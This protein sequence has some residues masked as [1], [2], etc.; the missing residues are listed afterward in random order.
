M[1]LAIEDLKQRAAQAQSAIG[2][3]AILRPPVDPATGL[4]MRQSTK[5]AGEYREAVQDTLD[6]FGGV[7][8]FRL[9]MGEGAARP[10]PAPGGTAGVPAGAAMGSLT[11]ADLAA[12][13]LAP[14]P[15]PDLSIDSLKARAAG[16][17]AAAAGGQAPSLE[18][19]RA[20]IRAAKGVEQ[21]EGLPA[22][23]DV[24][25]TKPMVDLREGGQ[26]FERTITV[27]EQG[28]N[29][30]RP[31]NIPTIWGGQQLSDDQAV[32]WA[33]RSGARFPS[34]GTIDEAVEVA[35]QRS[36]ALGQAAG[37]DPGEQPPYTPEQPQTPYTPEDRGTVQQQAA[38][39]REALKGGVPYLAKPVGEM[40]PEEAGYRG[41]GANLV[42]GAAGL[43][44]DV[45]KTLG[46]APET[47]EGLE[48]TRRG[49]EV[50]GREYA[51]VGG[52][53]DLIDA[54]NQGWE[55]FFDAVRYQLGQVP[56]M[57][58]LAMVGGGL[59]GV[60]GAAATFAPLS[61]T[62]IRGATERAG[63]DPEQD[64]TIPAGRRRP[65]PPHGARS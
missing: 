55:P 17:G 21:V 10:Q 43:G 46:V 63:L 5:Q 59:A 26:S 12:A 57:A 20:R 48:R 37:M 25:R 24:A 58:G 22:P 44:A 11:A 60:P 29:A 53:Q 13:P 40:G 38:R 54:Y 4:S 52:A 47:A 64:Y 65:Q 34:Y 16:I 7:E 39:F 6:R 30:G 49:A 9:A 18:S 33:I 15:S 14:E 23:E 41:F 1:P 31:T 51:R 45:L 3:L 8:E 42:G 36:Q 61:Y 62:E 35:R 19:L 28:L 2:R 32:T 50:L 56:G 27:T